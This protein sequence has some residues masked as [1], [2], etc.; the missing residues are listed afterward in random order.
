MEFK[1][2]NEDW[3]LSDVHPQIITTENTNICHVF[4]HDT[5]EGIANAHLIAAAPELL[6]ALQIAKKALDVELK[7]GGI[8][9]ITNG[10]YN[11]ID[12]AINKALN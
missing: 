12:Q 8:L 3:I 5:K 4:R 11:T 9:S 10:E 1:G 6:E 2:N 7:K